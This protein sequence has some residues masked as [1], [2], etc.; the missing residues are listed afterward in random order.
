MLAGMLR[1]GNCTNSKSWFTV[2]AKLVMLSAR[3]LYFGI[4]SSISENISTSS[5]SKLLQ[6]S[7]GCVRL[8]SVHGWAFSNAR[9]LTCQASGIAGEFHMKTFR[10][11][12]RWKM[13]IKC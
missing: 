9:L 12:A 6:R 5:T 1:A 4:C 2:P 13:L 11:Q 7:V 3:I 8:E 10:R